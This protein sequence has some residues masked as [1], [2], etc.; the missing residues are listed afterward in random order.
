MEGYKESGSRVENYKESGSR[1]ENYKESENINSSNLHVRSRNH[2]VQHNN[3][4]QHIFR[5]FAFA[6]TLSLLHTFLIDLCCVSFSSIF[7]PHGKR[8]HSRL[9]LGVKRMG[10]FVSSSKTACC[11]VPCSLHPFSIM[12]LWLCCCCARPLL[13]SSH[14]GALYFLASDYPFPIPTASSNTNPSLPH[15]ATATAPPEVHQVP[16]SSVS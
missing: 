10:R 3:S 12:R 4:L 6:Y 13:R 7:H 2:S 15:H 1:V 16:R 9:L 14:F 5:F 8:S 11:A